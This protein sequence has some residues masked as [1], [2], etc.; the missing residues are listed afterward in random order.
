[1]SAMV[2]RMLLTDLH[3]DWISDQQQETKWESCGVMSPPNT[4][5]VSISQELRS[6][7]ADAPTA[8]NEL[9]TA[10]LRSTNLP[11][12]GPYL[13]MRRGN[14][15]FDKQFMHRKGYAVLRIGKDAIAWLPCSV[16]RV[17]DCQT[18]KEESLLLLQNFTESYARVALCLETT[19]WILELS[20]KSRD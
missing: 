1:M 20:L 6:L 4:Q 19:L 10:R 9:R 12:G 16:P 8:A 15:V 7:P 3:R 14:R 13:S 11:G 18:T 17:S 2:E 5:A